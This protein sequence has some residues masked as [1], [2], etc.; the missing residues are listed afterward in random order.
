MD[1]IIAILTEE[2]ATIL[3][4]LAAAAI[5]ALGA[6]VLDQLRRWIGERRVQTLRETL[7]PAITRAIAR[8]Q[9][10]GL[11]GAALTASASAYLAD[12][13]ADTIRRLQV[14]ASALNERIRAEA[15]E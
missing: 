8:A 3:V 7:D 9:K 13:M 1:G 11:T 10:Q 12:T 6:L 4:S 2:V 14:P 5:S 15:G